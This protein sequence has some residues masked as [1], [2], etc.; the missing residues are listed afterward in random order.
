MSMPQEDVPLSPQEIYAFAARANTNRGLFIY[1]LRGFTG[2]DVIIPKEALPDSNFMDQTAESKLLAILGQAQPPIRLVFE[3]PAAI[4]AATQTHFQEIKAA[5]VASVGR[6]NFTLELHRIP[7]GG[8][9]GYLPGEPRQP[10][11]EL[12]KRNLG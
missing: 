1:K 2:M 3:F 10:H 5:L 12:A 4:E 7:Q 8:V 11:P 9:S 6:A